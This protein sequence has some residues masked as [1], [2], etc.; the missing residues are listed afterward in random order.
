VNSAGLYLNGWPVDQTTG[1]VNQ[2][3]L[4]P[5]QVSQTV[6]NPV[7][8]TSVQLSANLP[9]TPTAGT[10]TTTAPISSDINLYDSLGTVHTV[11]LNWVQN[12]ANDW[13]VSVVA[14]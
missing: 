4:A 14:P 2:N 7:A 12:A 9:A 13:T 5:V 8:T 1:L 10:A 3:A 11:A 6:F